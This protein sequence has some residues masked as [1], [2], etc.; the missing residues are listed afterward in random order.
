MARARVIV[1]DKFS[2]HIEGLGGAFKRGLERGGQVAARKAEGVNTSYRIQQIMRTDVIGVE[3][4]SRGYRMAIGARDPRAI[5]FEKGTRGR[6]G[7]GKTKAAQ[8]MA[9]GRGVKPVRFL[10]KGMK[11]AEDDIADAIKRE[12]Q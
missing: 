2:K 1:D 5:W 4:M 7:A 8:S 10:K 6:K 3:R 9:G 11:A 12:L